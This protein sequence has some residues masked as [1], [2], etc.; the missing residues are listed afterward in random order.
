MKRDWKL[1]RRASTIE[2]LVSL[3]INPV[4]TPKSAKYGRMQHSNWKCSGW[5]GVGKGV[6]LTRH[7]EG[8]KKELRELKGVILT[9]LFTSRQPVKSEANDA[10]TGNVSQVPIQTWQVIDQQGKI[11]RPVKTASR[12]GR[13][14]Q[15]TTKSWVDITLLCP[16]LPRKW[17]EK[18][19][20]F[21]VSKTV[22]RILLFLIE[23][24]GLVWGNHISMTIGLAWARFEKREEFLNSSLFSNRAYAK[25]NV[26]EMW[27]PQ[28]NP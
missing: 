12:R 15:Q 14:R 16:Y 11:K 28:T 3:L 26:M 24:K 22:W 2:S 17:N 5:W 23:C 20:A 8:R 6:T 27:L 7:S 10:M 9:G 13:Q 4:H 19:R 1:P 25:P 18:F 21:R